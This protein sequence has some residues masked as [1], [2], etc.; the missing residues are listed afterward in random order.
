MPTADQVACAIVAAARETGEDPIACARGL[1]ELRCRHYALHALCHVFGDPALRT[2]IARMVGS[3]SKPSAFYRAS[4]WYVL[5]EGPQ[6]AKVKKPWW[7][8]AVLGR[9]IDAL[10]EVAR[11][12]MR[13]IEEPARVV[14][15]APRSHHGPHQGGQRAVS[16]VAIGAP[17]LKPGS[18]ALSEMLAEAVRNTARMQPKETENGDA[19][20]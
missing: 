9:V 2:P 8:A 7:D 3:P 20:S 19:G 15:P 16:G 18:Q 10:G 13:P 6:G 14:A 11:L 12:P 5:G 4:V 1:G 17:T